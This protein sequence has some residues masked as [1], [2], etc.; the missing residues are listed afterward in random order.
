MKQGKK[1]YKELEKKVLTS[2]EKTKLYIVNKYFNIYMNR[3]DIKGV[4]YEQKQYI[5]KK[6]WSDGKIATF[7]LKGTDT[8]EHPQ[9]LLVFCPFAPVMYNLYDEPIKVNLVNTR[10]VSFIPASMQEVNKDVVLIYAQR[11]RKP[12]Y[13]IVEYFAK[14]IALVESAIQMNLLAQKC[15]WLLATSPDNKEKML[16]FY[17]DLLDDTNGLFIDA[18]TI[19]EIKPLI[20][21][22]PYTIDKLYSHKCSLENELREALGLDNL[23]VQEKKEH[24]ITTEVQANNQVV[25]VSSDIFLD[26]MQ[27]GG[28]MVKKLFDYPLEF[29]CKDNA[30]IEAGEA[31]E[32][33][34]DREEEDAL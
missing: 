28:L 5:L 23:G 3:Y 25:E 17:G 12:V 11:N 26:T 27:E 8:K 10:G 9:G 4:D 29:I 33:T 22:A 14:K 1:N 13:F 32:E 30:K 24:L 31:E 20:T 15:P 2:Y 19:D 6:F 7:P 18:K 21:G 16:N 34:E